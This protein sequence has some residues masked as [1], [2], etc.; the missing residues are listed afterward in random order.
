M[1]LL[2]PCKPDR[3]S[4]SVPLGGRET[5]LSMTGC[6]AGGAMYALAV[7]ELADAGAVAEVLTQWQALTLSHMRADPSTQQ[8]KPASVPGADGPS[9]VLVTARGS[10][11]DGQAIEGQALFFARGARV[12][13]AVIYAPRIGADAAD[14]FFGGMKLP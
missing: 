13:Q 12:F 11:P 14:T 9:P 1:S 3:A 10:H 5:R 4:K 2:L 8:R 6:E 7:A